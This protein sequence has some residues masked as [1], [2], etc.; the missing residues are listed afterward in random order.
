MPFLHLSRW[1]CVF[2]IFS[3]DYVA[4]RIDLCILNLWTW[5]EHHLVMVYDLFLCVVG[6]GLLIL[7]WEFLR[8]YL[9]RYWLVIFFFCDVFVWF[10][11]QGDDDFIECH[12]E[13]SLLFSLLEEFEKDWDTF[14]VCLVEFACETIWS[15]TFVCRDFLKL[16]ILFHF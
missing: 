8:L 14:F 5:D 11:Y 7:C 10:W 16:Q 6:L 13:C 12:W 2:F 9:S 3:F 1:S 4:Y 15:W